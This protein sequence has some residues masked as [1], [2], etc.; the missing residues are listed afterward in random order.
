MKIFRF[1]G[2]LQNK[3]WISPA[4]VKVDN[5]G[6]IVSIDSESNEN[7]EEVKG[8]VVPAFPNAH[9][10]SFQYA[11][12]GLAEV[13]PAGSEPDDFWSWREA[14][15]NLALSVNPDEFEDIAT[16]LY[17][18]MIRHGYNSVAEFHYVHHDK[19]GQQ[20]S[21]LAELGS[22][23]VNAAKKTGMK[24]T[25]IPI[26]YQKGGFGVDPVEKQKR[27]ISPTSD[28]YIKLFEASKQAC[29]DY[30]GANVA[31]GI[32]SMRGVQDQ[33]IVE[34]SKWADPNIAFHIHISEQL[35]E[36]EDS[37]SYLGKRPVEW[38]LDNVDLNNKYQLVHATHLTDEETDGIAKSGA[39]VVICPTTE[40]NLGDGI[41]PLKRF[42]EK[43]GNWCIGTDSHV[44]LNPLEE[45]R[46]LDYGQRLISHK[47]NTYFSLDEGNS[48]FYS[49]KHAI[50]NGRIAVNDLQENFFTIG[51][52]FDCVVYD[53]NHPLLATAS[54]KYWM[55]S[56]IY[57][58]DQ[59]MC[60][61]TILR[62]NWT[63]KNQKHIHQEEISS[64]F[65]NT[66]NK[67]KS[68]V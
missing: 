45:L 53:M 9:S 61:G 24:L 7:Y 57:S 27:F 29:S 36:I 56:I 28:D 67:L 52:D 26:F 22:R 50:T 38:L 19:N 33:D 62:G 23:L 16:M 17:S 47:R 12:A 63:V 40:G 10:H 39:Q 8:L 58:T 65:I 5:K 55:S 43:G 68:R 2:L 18:E 3:E 44:S 49:M 1:E 25:L 48:G 11:M 54:S 60:S 13:H 6:K 37:I 51:S 41:F 64:K 14:M 20:Y 42:Q 34:I 30:D 32:H 66:L 59:N 15:Y 46:L 4:F 35:K 31:V 21:N